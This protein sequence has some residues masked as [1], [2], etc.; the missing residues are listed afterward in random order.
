M[1]SI[2]PQSK[3][4][5][6][7]GSRSP[8]R[9]RT[10]SSPWSKIVSGDTGELSSPGVSVVAPAASPSPSP[11]TESDHGKTVNTSTDRCSPETSSYLNESGADG[12][13]TDGLDNSVK[14]PVW[15]KPLNGVVEVVSPVMGADS[16]PALGE[17]TKAATK[18]SSESL[19][20]LSEEVSMLPLLVS[21]NSSS[22]SHKLAIENN[23]NPVST[24]NHL[25]P[26]QKS[27]KRGGGSSGAHISSNEGISQRSSS[28]HV[29]KV[30]AASHN[31]SVKPGTVPVDSYSKDHTHKESQNFGFGSQSNSGNNHNHQHQ[32]NSYKRGNASYHH[33]HGGKV[34][35]G[36]GHGYGNQEWNQNRN[37][38]NRDTNMQPQRGSRRGYVRPTV[39]NPNPF[40]HPPMRPFGHNVMYPDFASGMIYVQGPVPPMVAPMPG[41]IYFPIPDPLHADIVKQI[42]YYF[43]NENLVRDTFL[44]RNMDEQGWVPVS[45]IAGFNKVSSLTNDIQ[46]I[47]GV[48]QT[49]TLVEVQGDKLRRRNDWMRW[50]MPPAQYSS[51]S[52][53][54]AVPR[55]IDQDS[56]TSY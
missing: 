16:W 19:Q 46:L 9:S 50:L 38:N 37:Y 4:D 26:V 7:D 35:Q 52:S 45:L 8:A 20:G 40:I 27:I 24:A 10:V 53:F 36:Q 42:D 1:A 47:L 39:L 56:L 55:S 49:S 6:D 15:S 11:V 12:Q 18:S 43:S 29:S 44:R 28:S 13:P 51:V 54:E 34:G 23:A 2:N 31:T 5:C 32:K 17:S 33:N 25:T 41:P 3:N 22:S 48:M 21:G 14:K 30:E